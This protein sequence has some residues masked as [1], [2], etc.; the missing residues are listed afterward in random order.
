M[1]AFTIRRLL[2]AIPLLIGVSQGPS[3]GWTSLSVLGLFA[4]GVRWAGRGSD[5]RFRRAIRAGSD[6]TFGV[7][8]AHLDIRPLGHACSVWIVNDHVDR[9]YGYPAAGGAGTG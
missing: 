7:Y 9:A 3:W 2:V 8:L 6:A 5:R 1:V 4:L